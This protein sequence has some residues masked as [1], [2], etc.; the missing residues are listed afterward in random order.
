[1]A[2]RIALLFF[3]KGGRQWI[4]TKK[5]GNSC[6]VGLGGGALDRRES[7]SK[8]FGKLW[9]WGSPAGRSL[10]CGKGVPRCTIPV[11]YDRNCLKIA[12]TDLFDTYFLSIRQPPALAMG[13]L[14]GNCRVGLVGA[15]FPRWVRCTALGVPL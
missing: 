9:G 4:T 14:N 10:S 15:I 7:L 6:K 1:M 2:P 12:L 13:A 11:I 5:Q 3:L 8:L